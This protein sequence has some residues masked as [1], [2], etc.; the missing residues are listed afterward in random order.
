MSSQDLKLSS[1]WP[2]FWCHFY[3]ELTLVLQYNQNIR[4]DLFCSAVQAGPCVDDM[5]PC[6]CVCVCKPWIEEVEEVGTE[7]S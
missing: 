2:W 1:P 5:E 4:R 3:S 7:L 6:V